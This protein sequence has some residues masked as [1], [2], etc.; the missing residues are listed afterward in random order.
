[1]S[2]NHSDTTV[3]DP[4]N[5][6]TP[7]SP[8]TP[9]PPAAPSEHE[10]MIASIAAEQLS[11]LTADQRNAVVSLAGGDP[12]RQIEALKKLAPTWHRTP[13]DTAGAPMAPRDVVY[14]QQA[15]HES[16]YRDL[17]QTNPVLASRY[18]LANLPN[19]GR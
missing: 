14:G 15:D 13:K 8:A 1:M 3:L 11:H 18:L 12:L 19:G 9:T 2:T 10:A 4:A 5:P 7:A 6:A 16:V 17:M